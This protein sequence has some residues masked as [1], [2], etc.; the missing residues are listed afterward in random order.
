MAPAEFNSLTIPIGVALALPILIY[1][2]PFLMVA[3]VAVKSEEPIDET[4]KL[5][6]ETSPSD[7]S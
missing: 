2:N 1:F 3:K 4:T 5:D 7:S 6:A